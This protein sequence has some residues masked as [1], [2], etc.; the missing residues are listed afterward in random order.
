MSATA[1]PMRKGLAAT[2]RTL[3][4]TVGLV[5]A[6]A[7][8]SSAGDPV[9]A[10]GT[11][12]GAS[13]PPTAGTPPTTGTTPPTTSTPAVDT[14]YPAGFTLPALAADPIPSVPA[15]EARASGLASPSYI[16]PVYRTRVYRVTAA[17]DFPAA[18]HVRHD[19][20]RRQAFNANASRY[21]GVT[22]NGYWVL[23]DGTTFQPL[24]RGGHGGSLRGL[25]SDAEAIWHPTDPRILFYNQGLVWYAK[26]VEADHDSVM[27]DFRG[28]LPWPAATH[29]W[30]K[31]EGTSS[32]DGRWWAFMATSYDSAT[33]T[34]HIHGL[35]TY[36]RE[37]DRIVGTLDA[38]RFG[39][40]MPDHIS[41][42]PSGRWAVPSWAYNRAL[43]TRA[44][45]LDF[46]SFRQLHVDS[47]HSDLAVGPRGEDYYV[48][49]DY[50][51]GA[52]RAQD[53]AT[54]TT[55]DLMPLYPRSGAGYAAHVSGQAFGRPGWVVVSTYADT[56]DYGRSV[57]DPRLAPMHRKVMLVELKPGGRK[58][59]V[60]HTRA[61]ARYGGY[62]GEH[63]A[64][65][66]R[67]GTR[68]LFASN[69]DDGGPASS[70][71][72]LVPSSVYSAAPS[73]VSP[74]GTR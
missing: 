17:A 61:A 1:V 32:S 16:D 42:S 13:A 41:I 37:Q 46:S 8:G 66:S 54:G 60:A 30:T 74:R 2:G 50:G 29:V 35:V 67:D 53:I 36:D 38:S 21:L 10:A 22:S 68:I 15:P 57:P 3:L 33:Q 28:R 73:S 44:Y 52:I 63:Q 58:L 11:P 49:T 64:T 39:R 25:A 34:N 65:I 47:E 48:Y 26:D 69:F 12:P 7:C 27:A 43:G 56:A 55:F 59:S 23:Y 9:L 6:A 72:V 24:V 31:A 14:L 4:A 40:A 70:Y 45:P 71:L 20:S 18:T 51:T 5:F 62:Y 19:Y